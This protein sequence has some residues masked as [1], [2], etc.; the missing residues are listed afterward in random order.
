[1]RV[2]AIAL[3]LGLFVSSTALG[4]EIQWLDVTNIPNSSLTVVQHPILGQVEVSTTTP[5]QATFTAAGNM[6]GSLSWP[7]LPY[8]NYDAS[9][10]G[11]NQPIS[12]TMTFT[13]LDGAIDSTDTLYF[14]TNG[15]AEDSFYTFDGSPLYLGDISIADGS[16]L[17]S[18]IGNQLRVDG[19]GW[20]HNP[21][22]FRLTGQNLT[23]VHV[24]FSQ[25]QGDGAGF[26]L[27]AT[28]SETVSTPWSQP[29]S[30]FVLSPNPARAKVGILF[31][32]QPKDVVSL[33]ILD[34]RGSLVRNLSATPGQG[35]FHWFGET[36][37]GGLAPSGIYF[38]VARTKDRAFTQT[39]TWMR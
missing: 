13:F 25:K 15:L 29:V 16:G 27:G 24:I 2:Y 34:V 12:G 37:R 21:D 23:Q 36:E 33:K 39:L 19:V 30:P 10:S 6:V 7:E 38:V 14:S 8:I 32:S 28:T 22:L 11:T 20:N 4:Q 31:G 17:R 3:T 5:A 18:T 35:A 1:M 9:S 26:N